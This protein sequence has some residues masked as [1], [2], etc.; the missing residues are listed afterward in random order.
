MTWI[1]RI[2]ALCAA[3]PAPPGGGPIQALARVLRGADAR[4]EGAAYYSARAIW[5]GRRLPSGV[6]LKALVVAVGQ[7]D[8]WAEHSGALDA[9][10]R[11]RRAASAGDRVPVERLE[12][13]AEL[14]QGGMS[15]RQAARVVGCSEV[16]VRR[17][18]AAKVAKGAK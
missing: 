6:A 1:D 5:L 14:V 2:Q 15:R 4:E 9:E 3:L 12:R 8:R 10:R 13:A 7:L 16:S 11:L 17:F 18:L